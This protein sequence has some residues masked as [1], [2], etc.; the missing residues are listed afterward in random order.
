[1]LLNM[2]KIPKS[3]EHAK[4]ISKHGVPNWAEWYT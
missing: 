1:M 4:P 3:N 2:T